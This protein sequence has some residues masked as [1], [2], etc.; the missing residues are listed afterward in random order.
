MTSGRNGGFSHAPARR[1][2]GPVPGN[3]YAPEHVNVA[4]QRRDPDSLLTF[5]RLLAH[6]YRECPELG[7]GDADVLDQPELSVLALRSTWQEASMVT[8]HNLSP[9]P[10]VVRLDG[11][12][13][14]W[15]RVTHPGSRRLL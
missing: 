11:Y 7:W 12:G 10:V 1:L 6:R 4:D 8:V 13:Y 9:D 15:L 3:G 2:A 5:V 14:R